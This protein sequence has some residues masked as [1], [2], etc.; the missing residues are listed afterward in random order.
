MHPGAHAHVSVPSYTL[1]TLTGLVPVCVWQ[2]TL[3]SVDWDTTLCIIW[4]RRTPSTSPSDGPVGAFIDGLIDAHRGDVQWQADGVTAYLPLQPNDAWALSPDKCGNMQWTALEAVTRHPPINKDGSATLIEVVSA[5][6]HRVKVT[7]GKSLLVERRGELV[8]VDGDSV[9]LG[10]RVPITSSLPPMQNC[11]VLDLHSVFTVSDV[12]F[13]DEV[14]SLVECAEHTRNWFGYMDGRTPFKR[15]GLLLRAARNNPC[16]M[17]PGRVAGK[18]SQR[19]MTI[20][21][22]IELDRDFGFFIGAYLASGEL[23]G[24]DVRIAA[25]E[26]A[27]VL[28]ICEWYRKHVSERFLLTHR[29][30]KTESVFTAHSLILTQLIRRICGDEDQKRVPAFA[31][32]APDTFVAGLLD[33]L[34]S[35]A[36]GEETLELTSSSQSL[37][38]G[39]SL[40]LTR[41]SVQCTLTEHDN[42]YQLA[43]DP[44]SLA[45]FFE[46]FDMTS[47][48]H[49]FLKRAVQSRNKLQRRT[50]VPS[51]QDVI[52]DEIVSIRE[53]APTRE[54]VYDLTVH[55][56]RN[57]TSMSG[58]GLADT[59]HL[60]GVGNKNVTLGIPRLKELLDQSRSIKTPSNRIRFHHPYGESAEFADYFA[61]TLP[62][63]RLGDIV[64]SCD[65]VYDP[66]TNTT[67]VDADRIIVEMDNRIYGGQVAGMS[68][69]VVRLVLNQYFMKTRRITPPMV[70][71]LLRKRFRQRAHVLSSETNQVDW[72]LRIRFRHMDDMM[73]PVVTKNLREYEGLLCHRVVSAMLDTIAI[74]GHVRLRG[75]Q[76]SSEMRDGKTEYVVDTQG[77][78]LVDLSAAS[79]VD[80]Y[81]TTSNDINEIHATLGMEAA[82]NSLFNELVA[83]I[84]FDGTYV[85]PRHIMMI[86]NTMTCGGYIMP[87]SRHG[88]NRMDTGPLL[89]CS[90]EETPD[91]LCDAACFGERDNGQGVSQ[92]IMTGKLAEIGSGSMQIRAGPTM[93]HPRENINKMASCKR[94]LKSTVRQREATTLEVEF[95]ERE[96]NN[97]TAMSGAVE[98]EP[99]FTLP[100][101]TEQTSPAGG[102]IFSTD[103]YQLPYH[104]AHPTEVG[105]GN[106][107]CPMQRREEY[108]PMSPCSDDECVE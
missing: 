100:D 7:K 53:V 17:T 89:R 64:T 31:L 5:K 20:P 25:N 1:L 34:F 28:G 3:N 71:T 67:T 13:T 104:D 56:T 14:I 44:A 106:Y 87:L 26:P 36:A 76:T 33:A 38:D 105:R 92:N 57:M 82:V 39:I 50:G 37:R 43:V 11:D 9:R 47:Q 58:F 24:Y 77:T 101:A 94:V 12:I 49:S 88:L 46:A 21:C 80:W 10:D 98:I 79:C 55:K 86:V 61:A 66:D 95:H 40:L 4:T 6:G 99:P 65:L 68:Q 42:A 32:G 85:D 15:G 27:V 63:T 29:T 62:L 69:Y 54:S 83:T 72:I 90:F 60:S 35:I 81:R 30:R 96:R 78:S 18:K 75:A 107:E 84:S 22:R 52:L 103:A 93:L 97:A 73:R 74:S 41:F 45:A 59:F 16:L 102:G 108:R 2:M 91:I 8:A 70:R 48:K 23:L 51:L 19:E